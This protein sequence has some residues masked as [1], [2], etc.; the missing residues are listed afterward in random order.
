MPGVYLGGVSASALY[1]G[2][3][4]VQRMYLG[5][6]LVWTANSMRDDFNRVNDDVLGANWSAENPGW[7]LAPAYTAGV[8]DGRCRLAIPDGLIS[9]DMTTSRH[10]YT[11]ATAA[12]DDG[13]IEAKVATQGAGPALWLFPYVTQV[14]GRGSNT[15]FTSGVGFQLDGSVIRLIRRVSSVDVAV[16]YDC[17][18]YSPGDVIRLT[19]VGRLFTLTK[20]GETVGVWNDSGAV[21]AK[22]ASNRSLLIRVDGSKD[23]LGPRRFSP[24]LDYVE[25][26]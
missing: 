15:G 1:L 21:T 2:S 9:L 6:T 25:A 22:G 18:A 23:L 4:P 17:G 13:Y 5:S 20:N 3:T 11:A 7:P 16:V 26:R 12:S 14:F 8:V 24:A 10:R 19:Y